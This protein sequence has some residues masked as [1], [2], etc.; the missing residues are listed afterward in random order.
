MAYAADLG[1]FDAGNIIDDSLFWD[2][3]A[4]SE[5]QIQTFLNSKVP[6]C[7]SGSTCLKN[8]METTRDIAATPM[9]AAY[10]GQ[11]NESAARIIARV[12][13]TCGVSPRVILV[14]LQKEQG[15]VTRT[16]PSAGNY[17][18]AMGAGCPDS[19]LCDS[20]YYGFFNQVH[21]GAFLLK[22]YTQPVGTGPGTAWSSRFDLRY[23]VGQTTAILYHPNAACGTQQV[24][25]QNQAT[26]ALY[27]YTP[28]TP[29]AAA[30]NAGNGTGDSCSSYG[31]RNF[32]NY[33]MDWFGTVRG[34]SV[35]SVFLDVYLAQGA[36]AGPLGYPIRAYACG[37]SGG[38]C[39][40]VFTGGWIVSSPA[41]IFGVRAEVVSVWANWGREV[42]IL[43]YP[44]GAP[45][46][47]NGVNY[48]QTFQGGT[49]T[50]TNSVGAVTSVSDP[51]FNTRLNTPWL[52]NQTATQTCGYAGGGCTQPFTGGWLVSSPAGAFA[53]R[54]EVVS[55]WANWGRQAG[56][57]G[58][59][60]GAPSDPNGV[61]YTQTF[62]GGTVT[63]TNSV[64]ST[65]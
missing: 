48:T 47:P 3:S 21:Y 5:A 25:I 22:R 57:L 61:N 43:G 64:A 34:P 58:Y 62:Q 20:A 23:P 10:V 50:V 53:L 13:Q 32:Y 9:C 2:G 65:E 45:S 14:T 26:H 4:M 31:N 29:N 8:Y 11:P 38:G 40:Q 59:P 19:G 60:T 44:T 54:T 24:T 41:G 56:I 7:A 1:G 55:L 16:A 35:A 30:L 17:R 36:G 39:Y 46:D 42:G 49:V 27:V 52:G 33:F 51:W 6:A 12:A 37:L 28:Y 63:V 18:S 15:L